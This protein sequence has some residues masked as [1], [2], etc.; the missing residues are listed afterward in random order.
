[1]RNAFA[2]EMTRLAG[3]NEKIVLL[4]GDIGNRLFDEYKQKFPSRF[5]NCGVAEAN[6]I[7]VAAGMAMCG[8]RPVTYTI[9]S[10]TTARCFEQIRVDVAYHNLPVVIVG[11]GGGLSYAENGATHQSCEDIAL[12]RTLPNMK[13]VCPGDAF[14]AA[15]AL[16]RVMEQDGPV[17]LRLGKKGEP[18]VHQA[19]PGLTIGKSLTI[20][21]GREVRLIATGNMLPTAVEAAKKLNGQGIAAGVESLHTVKPL[22][23]EMLRSAFSEARLVAVIEEHSVIGGVGAAVAQWLTGEPC[24]KAR[25]LQFATPDSFLHKAGKQQYARQSFGLTADNICAKVMQALKA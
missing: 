9:A 21:E 17:Y 23:E 5:Y 12:M 14:E 18:L 10:F 15:A 13:V 6:M 11:V 4:S 19:R 2:K 1:M 8:L 7:S 20:S 22:D 16:S 25:F 3:E 24:A